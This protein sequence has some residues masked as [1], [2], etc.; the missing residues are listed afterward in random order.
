MEEQMSGEKKSKYKQKEGKMRYLRLVL[1]AAFI[2]LGSFHALYGASSISI[3]DSYCSLSGLEI[4]KLEDNSRLMDEKFIYY[5]SA[6]A[7]EVSGDKAQIYDD[8]QIYDYI[9]KDKK[10][11]L[12]RNMGMVGAFVGV[13]GPVVFGGILDEGDQDA[14][15]R[16]STRGRI[17]GSVGGGISGYLGGV[18]FAKTMITPD[19][20]PVRDFLVG[21]PLGA[22]AGAFSGAVGGGFLLMDD[23]EPG[24]GVVFGGVIGAGVGAVV[25]G[26][27]GIGSSV[28]LMESRTSLVNIRDKDM[29]LNVPLPSIEIDEYDRDNLRY[30]FELVSVRF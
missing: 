1:L 21:I 6:S 26:I 19:P 14:F 27:A 28:Y 23:Y 8:I 24:V 12:T 5:Y 3:S 20:N 2:F 13:L 17:L 9:S 22:L 4:Y 7:D 11:A 10:A 16:V 18:L 25:G 15:F 29:S 30:S